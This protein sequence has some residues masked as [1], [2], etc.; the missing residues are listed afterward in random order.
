MNTL[1]EILLPSECAEILRV[2]TGEVYRLLN[3]KELIGY[4]VGRTWRIPQKNLEKYIKS[5]IV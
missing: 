2:S 3:S 5:K 4:H 1:E